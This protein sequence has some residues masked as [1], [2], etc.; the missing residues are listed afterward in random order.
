MYM[1]RS[2]EVE[3]EWDKGNIDKNYRKHGITPNEAEE[4][5]LDEWVAIKPDFTHSLGEKRYIAIGMSGVKQILFIVFTL[6]NKVVR[7]ISARMANKKERSIYENE[8]T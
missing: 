4:V 8:K 2:D 3:F 1:R 6:R 5:F 7:I